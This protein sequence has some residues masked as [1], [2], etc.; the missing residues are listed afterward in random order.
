MSKFRQDLKQESILSE[1]LD[2]VY[3]NKGYKFSR[4]SDINLQHQGID[5]FI[6]QENTPIAVDEKA[7]LHYINKTLPTFAFELSY[8]KNGIWKKGWLTDPKKKTEAY[9]LVRGIY[10]NGKSKLTNKSDISSV[11]ITCVDRILLLQYLNQKG[12]SPTVMDEYDQKIRNSCSYKA[13]EIP[14]LNPVTEGKIY[15]TDYLQER[16]INLVL[17]IDNLEKNKV[18]T[19]IRA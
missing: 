16:P 7:Q 14:E 13:N 3:Q 19:T 8:L 11:L 17:K 4:Q 15:F 6:Y 2:E 12:L 10:L 1:Y 5:G 9:F 18:A